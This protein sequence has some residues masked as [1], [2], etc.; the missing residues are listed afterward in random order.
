MTSSRT[1]KAILNRSFAR[2]ESAIVLFDAQRQVVFANPAAE[3]LLGFSIEQLSSVTAS[4]HHVTTDNEVAD[5]VSRICPPPEMFSSKIARSSRQIFLPNSNEQEILIEFFTLNQGDDGMIVMG[6][7]V[8][9]EQPSG[10]TN[11]FGGQ[12]AQA[13]SEIQ[14]FRENQFSLEHFIG[15][16]AA[17]RQILSKSEAAI[18]SGANVVVFGPVGCGR[19]H[20]ARSIHRAWRSKN[21]IS[22]ESSPLITIDGAVADAE[23]VQTTIRSLFQTPETTLDRTNARI[24]LLHAE[25]LETNAQHELLGILNLRDFD[26][27]VLA[28]ATSSLNQNSR[29]EPTLA[30]MLS[31]VEIEIP[32]LS[33]RLEDIPILAQ[34]FLERHNAKN[35]QQFSGFTET[36]IEHLI[37]YYWPGNVDELSEVVRFACEHAK[38]NKI[39]V[40]SLPKKIPHALLKEEHPEMVETK[41]DLDEFLR[42]IE[43]ELI[44]R[45]MKKTKGNKSKAAELL[46][47]NRARLIRKL[48]QSSGGA[49]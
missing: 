24:L 27:G 49:D 11:D 43:S 37:Q 22:Q 3:K 12:L 39:D 47:I 2:S 45:A 40:E 19:E 25:R 48:N 17:T 42:Q 15:A 21:G 33:Q 26:I 18:S 16:S 6:I 7:V 35:G 23:T 36:A 13:L 28:T 4:F 9:G 8:G 38:G 41:I 29:F 10:D 32:A 30:A 31:T 14:Q 20:L 46:G 5:V 34:F 1:A 44:E